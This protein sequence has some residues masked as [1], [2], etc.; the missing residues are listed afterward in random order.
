MDHAELDKRLR[1]L[2]AIEEIRALASRY[3]F[4]IDDR[5]LKGVEDCFAAHARFRSR[6]G[7]MDAAGRPAIMA[8]FERRFS[9]LG[10]GAHYTHDHVIILGGDGVSAQGTVSLHAELMRNGKPMLA[11]LRYED[12]Y[13]V[14]GGR[15]KFADRLLSFLYY[16]NVE[17]YLAHFP[18]RQ[19]NRAYDK[20]IDADLPAFNP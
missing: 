7:K 12:V 15:W 6:D 8:Q 1:R 5:D 14:E 17:D 13:C 4:A 16:L 9:V 3:V 2:E 10:H 18:R 19:R 20:P 11:S